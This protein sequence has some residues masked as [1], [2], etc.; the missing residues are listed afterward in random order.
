MK[1]E[2]NQKQL[3]WL[4]KLIGETQGMLECAA[5][6]LTEEQK[7]M[8]SPFSML[9]EEWEEFIQQVSMKEKE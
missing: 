5:I 9:V 7:H 4:H 8:I 1:L 6:Q 2:L 3:L